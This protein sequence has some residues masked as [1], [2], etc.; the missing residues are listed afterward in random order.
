MEVQEIEVTI[1]ENGQ[2]QIHVSGVK[3]EACLEITRPLEQ[4]LGGQLTREMTPE[5]LEESA[6]PID[7]SL[8]LK[9]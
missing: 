5:A 3:G 4:A 2:V 8:T 9:S 1:D 6:N 7:A